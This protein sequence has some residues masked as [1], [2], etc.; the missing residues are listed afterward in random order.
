MK[1]RGI[2]GRSTRVYLRTGCCRTVWFPKCAPG[3]PRY[4]QQVPKR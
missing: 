1:Q 2:K 4:S 3:I